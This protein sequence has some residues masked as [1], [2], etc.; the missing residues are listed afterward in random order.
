MKKIKIIV[1]MLI[2]IIIMGT[3]N[4]FAATTN[5]LINEVY[6]IG[7]KYGLTNSDKV[8][9]E[10]YLRDNPVT[11]AEADK[12][13]EKAKEIL[14][15]LNI[16]N[17][18]YELHSSDTRNNIFVLDFYRKNESK[19]NNKYDSYSI[20][21]GVSNNKIIV[22]RIINEKN[23]SYSN[24][25]FT[26]SKEDAINIVTT[27]EKEFSDIDFNITL[28]EKGIEKM[29]TYIYKLE[30]NINIINSSDN[31]IY[32]IDNVIRNVWIIKLEHKKDNYFL[33][34]DSFENYKKYAD[35][36]YYVDDNWGDYWW[37]IWYSQ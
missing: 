16:W 32:K 14:I 33:E 35:K 6:S 17:D 24:N 25:P 13:I 8:K 29:N 1:A 36:Y 30:N 15:P 12:L 27:K 37:K 22:Q 4:V 26:I 21:F 31:N 2:G 5:E 34:Y 11:E 18:N 10:R 20:S 23:N 19:I 9:I 28:C 3:A 7:S